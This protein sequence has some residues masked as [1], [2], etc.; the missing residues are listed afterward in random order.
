MFGKAQL[1]ET[2][3][4]LTRRLKVSDAVPLNDLT[5]VIGVRTGCDITVDPYDFECSE[6]YGVCVSNGKRAAIRVRADAL[7][8]HFMY[9]ACHELAH[10]LKG[11]TT[12]GPFVHVHYR[13]YAPQTPAERTTENLGR[14]LYRMCRAPDQGGAGLAAY[15]EAL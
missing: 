1:D 4:E 13:D 15:L 9:I 2:M 8:H 14:A 11:D 7:P 12:S 5:K 10:A 6:I 3:R